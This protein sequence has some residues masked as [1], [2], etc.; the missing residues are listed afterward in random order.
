VDDGKV[1][2]TGQGVRFN[3]NACELRMP[4]RLGEHT[5]EL[6]LDAG[7]SESEVESMIAS[8]AVLSHES[9]RPE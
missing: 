7:Y 8:A 3:G 4:P 5:R 9:R 1:R 6:L 2:L